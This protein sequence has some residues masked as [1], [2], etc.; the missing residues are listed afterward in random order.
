[1]FA[2]LAAAADDVV[3]TDAPGESLR[4]IAA[5]SRTTTLP[6]FT[7]GERFG[8]H[9]QALRACGINYARGA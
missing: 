4:R 9:G 8:G 1:V 6:T 3:V 2:G 5:S 7:P